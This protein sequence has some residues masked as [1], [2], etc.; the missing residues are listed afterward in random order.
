MFSDMNECSDP[1]CP[2]SA[3]RPLPT[4]PLRF[5]SLWVPRRE[6]VMETA[7]L[8]SDDLTN[9]IKEG[10]LSLMRQLDEQTFGVDTL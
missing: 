2:C 4:K 9:F 7:G 3:H 6:V 1:N 5:E 10:T 8:P